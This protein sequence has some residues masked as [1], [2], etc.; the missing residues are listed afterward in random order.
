MNERIMAGAVIVPVQSKWALPIPGP[1]V[2]FFRSLLQKLWSLAILM[3]CFVVVLVRI[4]MRTFLLE[5]QAYKKGK[6]EISRKSFFAYFPYFEKI[7]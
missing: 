6:R 1:Q 2:Y 3:Q 5:V 7:K 4:Y